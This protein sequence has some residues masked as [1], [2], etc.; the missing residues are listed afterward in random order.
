MEFPDFI[1]NNETGREDYFENKKFLFHHIPKTAGSTL[2][3]IL[4]TFF[5]NS[6]IC[7]AE[8][9]Q[10]LSSL[11][12]EEFSNYR[13]FAGHF[14]FG[15]IEKYLS[16]AVW[17][18]FLREPN[19]RIIS[20]YYNHINNDRIPDDWKKRVKNNP[21]WNSYMNAIQGCSLEEWFMLPNKHSNSI[22]CNRQTQ[23]FLPQKIRLKINDWSIHDNSLVQIAKKNLS[24]K[25][26]FFGIQEYFDLSFQLFSSTFGLP[27]LVSSSSF[28]TNINKN[29]SFG[30][31][32]DVKK[33]LANKI[34]QRNSMD[35]ELYG[36]AKKLFISRLNKA[37][38]FYIDKYDPSNSEFLFNSE[39]TEQNIS[40]FTN[41]HLDK[42]SNFIKMDRYS[43]LSYQL[44]ENKKYK[45]LQNKNNWKIEDVF[46]SKGLYSLEKKF[47]WGL[48]WKWT[49]SDNTAFIEINKHLQ[50]K[51]PYEV[52]LNFAALVDIDI[53]ESIAIKFNLM[54]VNHRFNLNKYIY[55][56][57][58]IKFTYTPDK[59]YY[60]NLIEIKSDLKNRGD[61][62]SRNLGIALTSIA[63][64]KL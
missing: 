8:T 32:Y 24:E 22:T 43:R 62:Y 1:R 6:E 48:K 60:Y 40:M 51:V 34:S 52:S 39:I 56:C 49:G 2:R 38:H 7:P 63:I 14:S 30:S 59:D 64:N 13:L 17:I 25:F 26:V 9:V 58:S 41:T 29:K 28:S 10:E 37:I 11:S 5:K 31:K 36:Y 16:N 20:Q 33:S 4:N 23:A 15:A 35:W 3:G 54:S 27:S 12:K 61:T 44:K 21:E 47:F 53:K 57:N 55:F 42:I 45:K 46:S 19:E 50:K 18:T